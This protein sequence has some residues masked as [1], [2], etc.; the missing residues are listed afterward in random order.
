MLKNY[1]T[2][3]WRGLRKRPTYTAIHVLGF[4]VGLACCLLIGL[5]V[6]HEWSYD[7]FHE[8]GNRI[9]RI[10]QEQ[11]LNTTRRI[12]VTPASLAPDLKQNFPEIEATVRFSRRTVTV[13]QGEQTFIN[14]QMLY[15]DASVFQIFSFPFKQGNPHEALAAPHSI[16]LTE[17][18]ARRYFGEE[19][20]LGKTI[21]INTGAPA[22]VYTVMGI[23]ADVPSN[24]H[25][26]Y[27]GL[28][29]FA[30][31]EQSLTE[32]RRKA[33]M[34]WT[35]LLL[36]K[37]TNPTALEA[38]FP[39]FIEQ[40]FGE[41]VSKMLSYE[42]QPLTDMHL[43][44]D[45]LFDN[46]GEGSANTVY[47]LSAV[48][49]FILLMAF[50]NYV[51][52]STARSGERA[53]E[54]GIRKAVGAQRQALVAQ[55]LTES[56][57]LTILAVLLAVLMVWLVLPIF[58]AFMG[59]PVAHSIPGGTSA[60]LGLLGIA[61]L[62]GLLA[63]TYPAFVLSN[64]SPAQ[65][66]KGAFGRSGSNARFRQLLVVFQFTVIIILLAATMI[67]FRQ[68]DFVRQ[69]DLGFNI[70]RVVGIPIPGGAKQLEQ[71]QQAWS[72]VPGIVEMT[73][74][75]R[76]QGI[77]NP[78]MRLVGDEE[79]PVS[80][81][82]FDV[83]DN[84]V[85][86][87]GIEMLA[88]RDF[89]LEIASDSTDAV[90]INAS[91]ARVLGWTAAEEAVGQQLRGV[92]GTIIGVIDDFHFASLHKPVEPLVLRW[93]PSSLRRILARIEPTQLQETLTRLE[94]SWK[95][96]IPHQPFTYAFLDDLQVQLYE[97]DEQLSQVFGLFALLAIIVGCL[98]L[99][100]LVSFATMQ[101][102]KEVGVRKVFGASISSVVFLF[103]KD[104]LKLVAVAY[105]M[106][107]P[108][109]Y[110]AMDHWLEGFA[111]RISI[112]V[113]TF[114]WLGVLTLALTLLTVGYRSLKAASA[115][116][117]ESLRYE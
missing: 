34:F 11:R 90:L 101:R 70:Q 115:N 36:R 100:G 48:V 114:L 88:G 31:L 24:S 110:F 95:R 60:A 37:G 43:H 65:V 86:V 50:I 39:A 20:P 109:A 64:F 116:P 42:L 9:Y 5:Y 112:G 104:F 62:L 113:S 91:A 21:A 10:A 35:Y 15:A 85:E 18:A 27:E 72:E 26:Q 108:I 96:H 75:S 107:V 87:M 58:S 47:I 16:V 25:L 28:R 45:L 73:A 38:D 79:S 74:V 6:Y 41:G 49:L 103:S 52:L 77:G 55:F 97:D 80:V 67:A 22:S 46:A 66:L 98:G 53:R 32:Q 13:K 33:S 105:V 93:R 76:Y 99:F 51:T 57:I 106:A 117:I 82:W 3:A 68:L 92:G 30:E 63:G 59:V 8:N 69:K 17:T 102:A 40:G 44:S 71:I 4:A 83:A 111:Y 78:P 54:V 89:S 7:R 81:N 84:Y 1:F 29:S 19:N 23:T 12:A 94:D 14:Q 56:V 2:T 61:L